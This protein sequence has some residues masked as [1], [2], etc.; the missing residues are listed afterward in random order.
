MIKYKITISGG[1]LFLGLLLM[2]ALSPGAMSGP[3]NLDQPSTNAPVVITD[4]GGTVTLE[5]AIVLAKINK[6][7]GN[8]LSLQYRGVEMLS[9]GGGYWNIYGCIPG[10]PYT[11]KKGTP[12]VF[13]ISQ[14][15]AQNGGAL[16]EIILRFPYSG[17]PQAVPLDIQIRYT[18]RCG[19][20]G[21]FRSTIAEHAPEYP[22]FNI[23][24]CTVCLK[25]NPGVFDFLSIDSRRQRLMPSSEDWVK[26]TQLNLWEAR[27]INTG[28]HKGEVEH[29]Y[30][31]TML[32]S[33]TP[34]WGWSST[35]S[36]VGLFVVNPSIEYI[37]GGPVGLDYGGHI[38]VKASLPADPTLLFI[39][40]SPHYG[41]REIQIKANEHWRKVVGPF[42][43]FCDAGENPQAMWQASLNRAAQEKKA[44]PYSWS[45][46]PGYE[47]AEQ[48]GSA[49][50]RLLIQDSQAPNASTAQAWVG[51]AHPA[52][53]VESKKGGPTT[54]DW[55]TDGKHYQYWTRAD[56]AGHFT[57]GNAR[58]G[59]YT[60]YAFTDGVLGDFSHADVHIESG[61]IVNLG[62]LVWTPVRYG[63]QLWDIGIPNRSAEEFR[64]GDHYWQWGLYNLYPQEFPNDVDFVI[65]KSDCR[66][67][68]NY[69]QPPRPNGKGGWTNTT[70]HIRFNIGEVP[71]GIATLRLAICGASVGPVDVALNGSHIGSTGDFGSGGCSV[72]YRDGI[73]SPS[74]IERDVK[75]DAALLK[76]GENI[77]SLTKHVRNWTDGVLY[78]YLRLELEEKGK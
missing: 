5:H 74:I 70:W 3:T 46:V 75:F 44:W 21:L 16:G 52:Y 49:S 50:G 63:R 18:L 34:A 1:V 51:L 62:E 4:S 28:I 19:D 47:H 73:R 6:A 54:I 10:Q 48:R 8:L 7:N 72:M 77:I 58:P 12:S 59:T 13:S 33:E 66:R 15:P 26:G 67:D 57:I 17:Q 31:Y 25:L 14:N 22:P 42:L 39:W 53:E 9:H 29:K 23:G 61:K 65:G 38:D 32:F 64:H 45:D 27:R 24:P 71:K 76:P 69:V 40:N 30:D 60:L 37:N 2:L 56:S 11:E 20:S 41:A 55:Q 68:W 43:L 36:K 35:K 78:D